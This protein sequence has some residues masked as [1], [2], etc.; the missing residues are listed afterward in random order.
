MNDNSLL[1]PENLGSE[2]ALESAVY[3]SDEWKI[4]PNITLYGGV[5]YNLYNYLG[6]QTIYTYLEEAALL[7]KNIT[8][9]I[10]FGN[11]EIVKTYRN[12]DF[13]FASTFVFSPEYSVKASYNTLHQYIFMLSNT[14]T[15]SPT[16][17]WKLADYHIKPLEGEQYAVGFYANPAGTVLEI[18][19]EGYYKNVN[20]LVE[21]RDGAE[22]L[23]NRI[24][25]TDVLSGKL[26]AYGIEL[27]VRK[28]RG[29]LNGWMNYTYATTSVLVN[30]TIP[31]NRINYGEPYPANYDKPHSFNLVTNYRHSRRLSIS[32][33]M[34]YGTG[35]PVTFPINSYYIDGSR[36]I[37][38]SKRN[39]FRLNDYFRVDASLNFEGNLKKKKLAHG[40][41][42]ISVYNLT[43]RK[44]AYSV[45]FS[46]DDYGRIRGYQISVFGVPIVTL[47]Y[48]IKLGNYAN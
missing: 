44:N 45:F 48:N 38:Y 3:L 17:K 36:I 9:T 25:E 4:T 6:P 1:V 34:V 39:E 22:L 5:R 41:W 26:D 12:L 43:G 7:E 33:N 28:K 29:K 32:A 37:N 16:T 42:M 13:R 11:N 15:I 2:K 40:T 19:V 35:R 21:Y 23:V 18:S 20:N 30:S 14:I 47:T 46:P 8:G 31:E 24:P 27:M 10:D